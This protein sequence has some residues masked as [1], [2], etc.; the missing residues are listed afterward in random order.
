MILT[1]FV[2]FLNSFCGM[3]SSHTCIVLSLI[4]IVCMYLP[5]TTC[6][7]C[8]RVSWM[9]G[10]YLHLAHHV[11]M[12]V[13]FMECMYLCT[14]NRSSMKA[15]KTD[16]LQWDKPWKLM[17]TCYRV[18]FWLYRYPSIKQL[19]IPAVMEKQTTMKTTDCPVHSHMVNISTIYGN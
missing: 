19:K 13:Q 14:G 17:L 16:S 10:V 11:S 7:F 9:L 18:Q 8:T 12:D 15:V 4:H 1:I 2:F 6:Y 5:E 3:Y